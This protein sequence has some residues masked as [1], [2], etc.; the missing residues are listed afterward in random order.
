[1]TDMPLELP[2]EVYERL[3]QVSESGNILY[4][5][6]DFEGALAKFRSALA[7]LPEP[8]GE[9]E[10]ATWCLTSIGDC[11]FRLGQ[12]EEARDALS[13]AVA[14]PGGL[15][16]PFI[17]LRLGQAQLELGA[18]ERAR[19]ELARAYMGGGPEIFSGEHSKYLAYLRRF[20]KGI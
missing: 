2:D 11:L 9:W 15:G 17:H 3:V 12:Y 1:M 5:R 7:L 20:M 4:D 6:A 19:D 13:R 14:A 10:A 16:N 8:M 18:E